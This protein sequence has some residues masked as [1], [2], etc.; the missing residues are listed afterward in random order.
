MEGRKE[1][2]DVRVGGDLSVGTVSLDDPGG[3]SRGLKGSK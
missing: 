1:P 2:L 3:V